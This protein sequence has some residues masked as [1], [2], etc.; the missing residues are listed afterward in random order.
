M[1]KVLLTGGNGT[2][3][4]VLEKELS[5]KY[6]VSKISLM[7]M[8]DVLAEGLPASWKAQL[9]AFRDKLMA[10]LTT[11][12]RGQYAVAHLGWNTRDEN[13]KA[14]LDPLNIVM[15]DCVYQAAIAE[16]VPR[17]YLASSVHAYDFLPVM[18]KDGDP[19]QPFPDTRETPFG[20]GTTSL[21][22]VSKRWMEIAG[23]FYAKHLHPGQKILVVRLGGV[24]RKEKPSSFSRVWDSHRDCAGLLAAFIECKDDAPNYWVAFNVSNNCGGKLPRPLFDTINPYGFVPQDNS[25][26]LPR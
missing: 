10:Q 20:T 3:A 7:R 14:G 13:W 9:D 16:K 15:T 18:E 19:I 4:Y 26:D 23:Q 12:F 22:G 6:E 21:Y 17:I 11:A 1:K 2:V 25:F 5:A 24:G 8:E